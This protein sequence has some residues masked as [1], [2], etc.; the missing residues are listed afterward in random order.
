M[1]SND[2]DTTDSTTASINGS[3]ECQSGQFLLFNRNP[4][5]GS[6]NKQRS[7]VDFVDLV[8]DRRN[9]NGKKSGRVV[10]NNRFAIVGKPS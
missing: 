7:L 1:A 10:S 9:W 6:A 4:E 3:N 8:L 2:G 5:S